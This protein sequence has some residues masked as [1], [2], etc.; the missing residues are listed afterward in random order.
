MKLTCIHP[1]SYLFM[2]VLLL[3][4]IIPL[5][6]CGG[7]GPSPDLTA[8]P[9]PSVTPSPTVIPGVN[10]LTDSGF[11]SGGTGWTT[12]GS[13]VMDS[14]SHGGTKALKMGYGT[15]SAYQDIAFTQAG[16]V[17][18]SGWGK[19]TVVGVSAQVDLWLEFYDAGDAPCTPASS[20][21]LHFGTYNTYTNLSADI[22]VPSGVAKIRVNIL[23]NT[24]V[25]TYGL[26]D[27]ISLIVK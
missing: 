14:D 3:T 23:F 15:C 8:T 6:G 9:T 20:G 16:T 27:D 26:L 17:T 2:M 5:A 12:T 1:K 24:M 19:S 25:D 7:G 10:L 22:V 21:V 4:A 11:E 13:G 18:L